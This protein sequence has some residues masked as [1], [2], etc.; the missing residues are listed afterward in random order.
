MAGE[1]F[2]QVY[3]LVLLGVTIAWA[4]FCLW[5]TYRALTQGGGVNIIAAAGADFLLGLLATWNSLVV[6]HYFRK[7]KPE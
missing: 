6:Q 2:K 3:A 1:R 7:A 4:V 5:I